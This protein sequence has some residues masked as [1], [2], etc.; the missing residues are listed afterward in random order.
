[1]LRGTPILLGFLLLSPAA[2]PVSASEGPPDEKRIV[3]RDGDVIRL[4]G[5]GEPLVI[6]RH[7]RM[8]RGFIGVR[9]LEMT[10]ELRVHYGA[11]REAGVLIGQ[12]DADG[13]AGKAG[14]QVGDIVTA[15]DGEKIESASDL[16]RAVRDKKEGQTVKLD[17][18]RDKARTT[19]SVAVAER[20]REEVAWNMLGPGRHERTIS[21]PDFEFHWP[22]QSEMDRLQ[23]RLDELEKKLH[24][25]EKR[26]QGKSSSNF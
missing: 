14:L 1:M 9:P 7:G 23:K 6:D 17:I 4:D 10:P 21:L 18:V 16:S 5:D 12:V 24:D 19:I 13:P 15:A 3:I 22:D 11:P 20:K 8:R 25:M 2:A 26:L